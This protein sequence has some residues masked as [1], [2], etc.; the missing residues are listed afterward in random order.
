V[1]RPP[2][3]ISVLLAALT[4]AACGSD[5][6]TDSSATEPTSAPETTITD[7]TLVPLARPDDSAKPTVDVPTE[8]PTELVVTD[9]TVGTGRA[10]ADGDL[11]V[12]DYVGVRTADGTEFDNS[13]ERGQPFDVQLGRGSV[14]A[15]WDQGLVGAQ[16]GGR[17]QRDIP[18]DLAYGDNPPAGSILQPGDALTFVIDVRA[19]VPA[20]DPAD[21][22]RDLAVDPSQGATEVSTTDVVI[23]EGEPLEVGQTAIVNMLLLKGDDT[24]VLYDTWEQGQPFV[25]EVVE[26]GSLPGFL[27]ALP[28][29]KVGGQRVIVMPPDSA[30]GPDGNDQLG[31]PADTDLIAVVELEG[32][33]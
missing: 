28:G 3:I 16:A 29:M 4:L 6:S 31:L 24:S 1:R 12:V 19:V 13:Y 8:I 22:P 17:R 33:F 18:A 26:G 30:F 32:A 9:L 7:G 15:G 10:A 11:V 14:I 23:G 21:A 2:V 20:P 5:S 27:D 25:I